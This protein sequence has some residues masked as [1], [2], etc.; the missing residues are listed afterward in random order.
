MATTKFYLDTRKSGGD[1]NKPVSL[2]IAINHRSGT[3]FIVLN[4]QLLPYQWDKSECKVIAHPQK[5]LLNRIAQTKIGA[6]NSIL[7][8]KSA[9]GR[10]DATTA[11]ELCREIKARL[12]PQA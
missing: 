4:I 2:K 1:K 11:T 10:T 8:E 5:D 9:L 3:G 12:E 6:V 7:L